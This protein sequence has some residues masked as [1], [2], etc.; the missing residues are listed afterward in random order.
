[1]GK[2]IEVIDSINGFAEMPSIVEMPRFKSQKIGLATLGSL[3]APTFVFDSRKPSGMLD[4]A[5]G[6]LIKK[7]K[8]STPYLSFMFLLELSSNACPE[9]FSVRRVRNLTDF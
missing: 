3:A 5:L 4:V 9:P 2:G 8:P 1:M 7:Q 6:S